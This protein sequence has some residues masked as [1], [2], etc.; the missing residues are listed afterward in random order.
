[1]STGFDGGGTTPRPSWS[2]RPIPPTAATWPPPA[3]AGPVGAAYPGAAAPPQP[4][5]SPLVAWSAPVPPAVPPPRPPGVPAHA[6][7]TRPRAA[8]AALCLVLG[9]GLLGG[10]AAGLWINHEPTA[11]APTAAQ[12]GARQFAQARALWHSTPV[13]A[14]FPPVLDGRG[15]GPGG[16]DRT[17]TRI[18]VAPP[19]GC[20][21][22]FDPLLAKVLRPAGCVKLLRATYTDASAG[23][24]TTVGLL[25]TSA[26]APAMH[27]LHDRWA[28]QHLGSRVDLMPRPVAFPGTVS[29]GFGDKQRATWTVDVAADLPVIVYA[30]SG[31]A[32]GRETG[33]PQPVAS[34]VADGAT[35]A[36]AQAGLGHD[37]KALADA[38]GTRARHAARSL[39]A[40]PSGGAR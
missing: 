8:A 3:A 39:T 29:A 22:A 15:A 34:A 19:S 36:P 13:D 4:G 25:V 26:D 2:P 5:P 33:A 23:A 40:S 7:Q 9:L 28:A 16:A 11:P 1:M 18:G 30:V 27:R 24:V 20:A 31:F 38:V 10:A 21:E 14:L 35:A 12:V 17:W 37:A 32:D 6:A